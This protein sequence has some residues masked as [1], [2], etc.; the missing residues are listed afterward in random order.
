M[1]LTRNN[2]GS[3]LIFYPLGI[4]WIVKSGRDIGQKEKVFQ[5]WSKLLPF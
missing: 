3:D 1:P 4:D 5:M 2:R